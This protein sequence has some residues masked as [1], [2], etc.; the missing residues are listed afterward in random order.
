MKKLLA[1]LKGEEEVVAEKIKPKKD[2]SDRLDLALLAA[3]DRKLDEETKPY[4]K[5]KV[6]FSPSDTND[7]ARRM[8]YLLRG[9]EITPTFNARTLR[10][11]GNGHGVHER[12][13]GYFD[14]LGITISK[15][16]ELWNPM[17]PIKAFLDLKI[18]WHGT[19]IVEIK[20]ISDA[21]FQYLL[22]FNK[23]KKDHYKQLQVYLRLTVCTQ[24][25]ILYENKNTQEFKIF[26]VDYNEKFVDDLFEGYLE[27]YKYF[28]EGVL[29][30][31]PARSKD[32][33]KCRQCELQD[34]CWAD[35]DKGK[36]L[37]K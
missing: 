28:M 36:K 10:I 22:D 7:C 9:T 25:Y 4:V 18:D 27:I 1:T 26:T 17:P 13:G 8:V 34:L 23:P 29:P 2:D 19:K 32:S 14:A 21:G 30:V 16:E 24:G 5:T 3:I 11:F 33:P 12:I 37:P 6:G 31:R 35:P 15:E 20:S